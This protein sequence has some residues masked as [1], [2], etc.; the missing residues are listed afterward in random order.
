MENNLKRV[1]AIHDLSSFG[2]CSLSVIM[3]IISAMGIQCCPIPTAILSTHT[4]GLG[5]F[6]L[7]DETQFLE[8]TL[9][10]YKQLDLS[11]DAV[12]TGFLSSVEQVEH[13]LA[14]MKEYKNALKV[15]DPVM[16]DHGKRYSTCTDELQ[17]RMRNLV[18]VADIITPNPTEAAMLL[19]T[20]EQ[21]IEY[22][23]TEIKS[24]LIKLSD[25]GPSMVVITG[26]R[27]RGVG[28]VNVGY[29]REKNNFWKVV[30]DYVP[31]S[32]PGTG[33][34]FAAT[35]VAAYLSGDSFPIGIERATRFLELAIKT[36]YGYGTD[37][38]YGVLFEKA[39]YYLSAQN[40]FT[41]Y[42]S[43]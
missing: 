3:P 9:T 18:A 6:V 12:Y 36:T 11:F 16:G 19:G 2:R 38:R 27:L 8:D 28:L 5:D 4:G 35:L 1:A 41:G 34:M 21:G 33:D 17:A 14:Y 23:A 43:L 39:L 29:E 10:H 15:V 40:T 24:M 42:N 37:K 22:S 30:C 32:Y 13:C 25:I 26:I 7:R 31:I 20:S